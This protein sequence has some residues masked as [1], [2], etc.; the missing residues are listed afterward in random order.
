[1]K[2]GLKDN[3]VNI[4]GGSYFPGGL[5]VECEVKGFTDFNTVE[6]VLRFTNQG[7][8]NTPEIANIKVSDITFRN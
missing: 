6:W 4:T 7:K 3:S 5:K 8:K 1:M 2:D